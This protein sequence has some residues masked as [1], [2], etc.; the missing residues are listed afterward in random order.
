MSGGSTAFQLAVDRTSLFHGSVKGVGI[1]HTRNAKGLPASQSVQ[2]DKRA[3][4][5]AHH[6][7]PDRLQSFTVVA[8]MNPSHGGRDR[9]SIIESESPGIALYVNS[10]GKLADAVHVAGAWRRADSGATLIR[11]GSETPIRFTLAAD[12]KMNLHAGSG[13]AN[14]ATRRSLLAQ[15]LANRSLD[16]FRDSPVELRFVVLERPS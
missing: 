11:A 2:L 6:K 16:G 1:L 12:G 14:V 5:V 10:A 8:T 15:H 9:L 13:A 7:S 3:V 4:Q